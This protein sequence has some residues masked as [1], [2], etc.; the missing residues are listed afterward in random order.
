MIDQVVDFGLV[1][2]LQN[3]IAYLQRLYS[4]NYTVQLI[5]LARIHNYDEEPIC[6]FYV[7]SKTSFMH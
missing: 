4:A 6:C 3:E 7:E 2:L 5:K 1:S